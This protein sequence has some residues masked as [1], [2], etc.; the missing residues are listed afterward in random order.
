MVL[1][2]LTI[3]VNLANDYSDGLRGADGPERVGPF[4]LVGTGAARPES[5]LVAAWVAFAVALIVW[6]ALAVWSGTMWLLVLAPVAVAAAW[7][8][9]GGSVPYGYHGFGE[10]SVFV[11]YGFVGV[12]ATALIQIQVFTAPALLG[13]VGVGS[14]ATAVLVVNN[15]RDRETDQDAGKRTLA[16]VLGDRA[17]R[18]LFAV[19]VFVP[20]IA[21]GFLSVT[22]MSAMVGMAYMPFL[23]APLTEIARGTVGRGLIPALGGTLLALLVWSTATGVGLAF[24]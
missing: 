9:T 14:L 3:G 2:A 15:L 24:A 7:C 19:L 4:R 16:V 22:N 6:W 20:V 17:T 10:L 1:L 18:A 21:T 8:Y 13:A 11:W 12:L 5:V 23:T